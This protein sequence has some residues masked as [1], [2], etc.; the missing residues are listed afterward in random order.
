MNGLFCDLLEGGTSEIFSGSR[1]AFEFSFIGGEEGVS[2]S[3]T[4]SSDGGV[5]TFS[6][7]LG[8]CSELSFDGSELDLQF[9]K[10]ARQ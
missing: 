4:N 5:V 1:G 2:I 6:T 10:W 8:G 7:F 9:L 3:C